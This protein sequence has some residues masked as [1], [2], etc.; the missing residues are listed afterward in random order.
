[1]TI[2]QKSR[3]KTIT[4]PTKDSM[5]VSDPLC[6]PVVFQL[7]SHV[8]LCDHLLLSSS[9]LPLPLGLTKFLSFPTVWV[10][11]HI[12]QI[13]TC[14]LYG[15][16]LSPSSASYLVDAVSKFCCCCSVT[17]SWLTLC[18]LMDLKHTELLCPLPSVLLLLLLSLFSGV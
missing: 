16:A 8:Q 17:Q 18:D 11:L 3:H 1:M 13:I 5:C 4:T 6:A 14:A 7:L 10:L 15:L 12:T 9:S 2:P